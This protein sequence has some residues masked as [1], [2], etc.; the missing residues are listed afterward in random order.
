MVVA[1]ET[2]TIPVERRPSVAIGKPDEMLHRRFIMALRITHVGD[3][4]VVRW[5]VPTQAACA[6]V[7]EAFEA[8]LG[9]SRRKPYYIAVLP[10][11]MPVLRD[12]ER[13]NLSELTQDMLPRCSHVTV[14]VEPR[15][16]RGAVLRSA[17]SS[18]SLSSSRRYG[19]SIVDSLS[20]ALSWSPGP[21]PQTD[22]LV[23]A[24]EHIGCALPP[25]A[26]VA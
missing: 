17:M 11:D 10:H 24:L 20:S 23:E 13:A 12:V 7:R 2:L 19:S 3:L 16:F 25:S 22:E 15:G 14:V 5:D 26:R 1:S 9:R 8:S 21:L 4:F 6:R 18:I